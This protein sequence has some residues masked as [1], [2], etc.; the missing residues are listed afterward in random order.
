MFGDIFYLLSP[1]ETDLSLVSLLLSDHKER[2][3][4][5]QGQSWYRS[6]WI[7]NLL[8]LGQE[9][10]STAKNKNRMSGESKGVISWLTSRDKRVLMV[11]FFTAD[12]LET[13]EDKLL[14]DH[15]ER[16]KGAQGL[17]IWPMA[18]S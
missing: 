6:N 5:A 16:R 18:S 13:E 2:R 8:Y 3:K 7:I 11:V 9:P 10:D 4:G 17:F 14:S 15:K 1:L 12:N